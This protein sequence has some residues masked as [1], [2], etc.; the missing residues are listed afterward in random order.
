MDQ[1]HLY[2]NLALAEA[3]KAASEGEVPVGAVVV[4][5]DRVIGK[6]RNHREAKLDISSHAE[7]EALKA[8]AKSLG[9]WDLSGCALYVTLEPCLMCSG[10]IM[11]SRI[12]RLVYGADDLKKGA[13]TSNFYV[14]DDPKAESHP[15]INK[16]ILKDESEQL[17][18]S[19][20]AS[21][22]K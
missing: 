20:F 10:A 15:L 8:A 6:G 22:R 18:S 21:Q 14:F 7:I 1:D 2:M 3:N 16:G 19:F 5:G 12:T 13:V 11:Q 17:L 9:K 4:L